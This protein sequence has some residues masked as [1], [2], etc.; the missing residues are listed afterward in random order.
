MNTL[1][2]LAVTI[3]YYA[4]WLSV[5]PTLLEQGGKFCLYSSERDINQEGYSQPFNLY[6]YFSNKTII[7]TYGQKL[8]HHLGWIQE[9]IQNNGSLDEFRKLVNDKVGKHLQHEYKYYFTELPSDI[10]I[11]KARQLTTQDYPAYLHFF[12]T[13]YPNSEAE[14]WLDG[15]FNE[16]AA[17]GYVFGL[18]V[19]NELVSTTDA[20]GMPYMR[21]SVVE[22]GVSTLPDYQ[23]RGYA[24]IVIGAMLK[25]LMSIQK[26][27]IVS[28]GSSNMASQKLIESV[29]FIKLAD[30]VSLSLICG[31]SDAHTVERYRDVLL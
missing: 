20:P 13:Q 26:V 19:G 2:Y 15:Y 16:I 10:D 6:G 18:Y 3:R 23:G 21:E 24:K 17:K 9:F 22:L 8:E 30:V 4:E 5:N 14:T 31:A 29:G 1:N 28:C 7:I 27:P 25:F 11:S 12:K